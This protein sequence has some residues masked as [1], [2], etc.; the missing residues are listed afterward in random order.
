[1]VHEGSLPHSQVRLDYS[2]TVPTATKIHTIFRG[3][4]DFF[5][6]VWS[7]KL[8]IPQFLSETLEFN[9]RLDGKE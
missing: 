8:F 6:Y 2:K 4:L 1:M 7:S 9:G 5:H 3:I